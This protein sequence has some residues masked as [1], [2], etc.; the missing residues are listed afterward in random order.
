MSS[1]DISIPLTLKTGAGDGS[2]QQS[3]E[4][5]EQWMAYWASEKVIETFPDP[6][7]RYSKSLTLDSANADFIGSF[8]DTFYNEPVG[9]H[10]GTSITQGSTTTNLYQM[11]DSASTAR[12]AR[13]SYPIPVALQDGSNHDIY[14]MSDA[15]ILAL[16]QRI[17]GN[18]HLNGYAGAY[19]LSA[20]SPG[21]GW[22][23]WI[24]QVFTDTSTSGDNDY[25]IW[26]LTDNAAVAEPTVPV[27]FPLSLKDGVSPDLREITK[28]ETKEIAREVLLIGQ[29]GTGVGDYELRSS[30]QGAPTASG[31]WVARGTAVDTRNSVGDVSYAGTQYTSPTYTTQYVGQYSGSYTGIS[32]AKVDVQYSGS[33]VFTF[34]GNRNYSAGY[35]GSRTYSGNYQ[36][37]R[38]YGA[39]YAGSRNYGGVRYFTGG[40]YYSAQYARPVKYFETV[41]VQYSGNRYYAGSRIKP[42][43]FAGTRKI[44]YSKPGGYAGSRSKYYSGSRAG[45]V[46]QSFAGVRYAPV[47]Y[48]TRYAGVRTFAGSRNYSDG[49][50]GFSSRVLNQNYNGPNGTNAYG[51]PSP[52]YFVSFRPYPNAPRPGFTPPSPGGGGQPGN[53]GYFNNNNLNRLHI[54]HAMEDGQKSG[55]PES[56]SAILF[57]N[58]SANDVVSEEPLTFA[59]ARTRF[60]FP[61]NDLLQGYT[62]VYAGVRPQYY[63]GTRIWQFSGVR[64][65]PVTNYYNGFRTRYQQFNSYDYYSRATSGFRDYYQQFNG[66]RSI[67]FGG[68]YLGPSPGNFNGSRQKDVNQQ[69]TGPFPFGQAYGRFQVGFAGN[70]PVTY[71]GVRTFAG[72]RINRFQFASNAAFARSSSFTGSRNYG[73]QYTGSRTYSGDYQGSRNYSGDYTGSRPSQFTG[74]IPTTY[75]RQYTGQ[76]TGSYAGYYTSQYS[77]QYTG[78]TIT[79]QKQTIETFTLYCRVAA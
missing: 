35:Q 68:S 67:G 3:D 5:L 17:T 71:A 42:F 47:T 19:R 15:G 8:V 38:N 59:G 4:S 32:F 18:V 2:I 9:T 41:P 72:E 20:N 77:N 22:T 23:K 30:A 25:H 29:V 50:A 73:K 55:I 13:S 33:R 10:P 56:A 70:S 46:Q 64:F 74:Q 58:F 63:S 54:L 62:G 49:Y 51:R 65:Q 39:K 79:S 57:A 40:R 61:G 27:H 45:N 48:Y 24:D 14:E 36:G 28:E 66:V 7:S 1:A 34:A 12:F 11:A 43:Q 78:Q 16:A 37:S 60:P 75:S 26:R 6:T 76:Y 53:Q 69:F 52:D 31:Q 44:S 21:A